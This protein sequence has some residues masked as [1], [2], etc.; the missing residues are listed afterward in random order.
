MRT[1]VSRFEGQSRSSLPARA[2]DRAADFRC[3]RLNRAAVLPRPVSPDDLER[4]LR[5]SIPGLGE[6]VR[7]SGARVAFDVAH[8][9]LEATWSAAR[10]LVADTG[11]WPVLGAQRW[12]E[13]EADTTEDD[14]P[15][16][17]RAPW[18]EEATAAI[19]A[20]FGVGVDAEPEDVSVDNLPA[21]TNGVLNVNQS[22]EVSRHLAF[23]PTA[24]GWE[25]PRFL[26]APTANS[27]PEPERHAATLRQ[28]HQRWGAELV[29]CDADLV[30]V[31]VLQPPRTLPEIR[32]AMKSYR[33]YCNTVEA[34]S[35][36][37]LMPRDVMRAVWTFWWD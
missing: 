5:H 31:R 29:V 33:E 18:E 2:T 17:Y 14:E 3:R 30:E 27:G 22:R 32:E 37:Q 25:V 7:I 26:C 8:L 35:G 6:R 16:V 9:P 19:D 13:E 36:D 21:L 12:F 1:G 10:R 28:F 24:K 34:L 23:A 4:F 20:A 15:A 11:C